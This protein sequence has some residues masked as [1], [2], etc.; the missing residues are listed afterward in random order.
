MHQLSHKIT[1]Y[2]LTMINIKVITV[3][4]SWINSAIM[5]QIKNPDPFKKGFNFSMAPI[6]RRQYLINR[7]AYT[8]FRFFNPYSPGPFKDNL[9]NHYYVVGTP[10]NR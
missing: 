10:I 4:S 7:C 6:D 8:I 5:A 9:H 1:V 3:K 2:L